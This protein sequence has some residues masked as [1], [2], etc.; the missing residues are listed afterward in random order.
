MHTKELTIAWFIS[1][2]GYGHAARSSAIMATLQER[3]PTIRFEIFTKVPKWFFDDS[4]G[5]PFGY[6]PLMTDIGLVQ[7]TSLLEDLPATIDRLAEMIPFYPQQ[8]THLADQ[9][10]QLQCHLVVCDIAPMGLAVAQA[11]KLPSVLVENFT[12]DW[13]YENYLPTEP[14]FES[15]IHYLQEIFASATYHIQTEAVCNPQAVDLTT[16]PV[17]RAP[18]ET[19]QNIR[20]ALDLPTDAQ[21]VMISMGGLGWDYGFLDQ[22]S[23]CPDLYF[24]IPANTDQAK[25]QDNVRL[26]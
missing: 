17:S 5:Q 21:V 20:Q 3:H 23:T 16:Q 10:D 7:K 13:I 6:H 1:P 9:L 22:L 15:Y 12:W 8:I 14:R 26:L 4:L 2:H 19:P 24:V 18:K 25:F 11:A